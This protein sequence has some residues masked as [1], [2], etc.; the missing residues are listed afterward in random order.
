M[1]LNDFLDATTISMGMFAKTVGTTTATISRVADGTVVP[2]KALM[3]RIHAATAG[4]VTPNDLVGLYC[5][6]P[7]RPEINPCEAVERTTDARNAAID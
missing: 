1:K 5:V 3:E 7:C 6:Q 2:R 4:Q